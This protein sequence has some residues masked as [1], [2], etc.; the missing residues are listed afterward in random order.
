[1]GTRIL[2]V[3]LSGL[4][5]VHSAFAQYIEYEGQLYPVDQCTTGSCPTGTTGTRIIRAPVYGPNVPGQQQPAQTWRP[6]QPRTALPVPPAAQTR[7]VPGLVPAPPPTA[8]R[9]LIPIDPVTPPTMPAVDV[10]KQLA[11]L[12]AEVKKLKNCECSSSIAD[13]AARIQKLEEVVAALTSATT[14]LTGTAGQILDNTN[15]PS[16]LTLTVQSAAN[17]PASYV[18][19]ST[20][21]ALQRQTGISNAVLVV[22]SKDAEWPRLQADYNAAKAKFPGLQLLDV[23]TEGVTVS[24]TPQLVLYYTDGRQPMIISGDR[25]VASKLREF[26]SN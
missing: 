3:A 23:V 20:I 1:M 17:V 22:N 5:L 10:T 19:T 21:W 15:K 8:P 16:K 26:V 7:V 13:L 11:E 2:M 18:D 6:E 14:T 24:P 12:A 9:K 4:L 25:L